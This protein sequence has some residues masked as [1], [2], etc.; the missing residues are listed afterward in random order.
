[1][2][3]FLIFLM[4]LH[5]LLPAATLNAKRDPQWLM[6]LYF[7]D[8][9]GDRDTVYFG[10]DLEAST[11]GDDS[12]LG[13]EWMIIDTSKFNIYLFQYPDCHGADCQLYT[14]N[15][16][17]TD[18]RNAFLGTSI[19]FCKGKLPITMKWVDSLLYAPS[20]PFP[21]LSPRPRARIDITCSEYD[22]GYWSC[23]PIDGPPLSLTDYPAPEIDYPVIDSFFIDGS[24]VYPPSD[25]ILYLELS[26]VRHNYYWTGLSLPDNKLI[27]LFPNPF[28]DFV[29]IRNQ[30][31]GKLTVNVMSLSGVCL[32][33]CE[34]NT[35]ELVMN[36][37]SLQAGVYLIL[38]QTDNKFYSQKIVKTE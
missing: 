26:L 29:T 15:V 9:N 25:V 16:K 23:N 19:G 4:Q 32:Y 5:L 10:Y 13:E 27:E 20:C 35:K 12:F 30:E 11:F 28:I 24:G 2:K 36:L 7:R 3:T 6:P 18:I 21:D 14:N 17:K 22:P 8:A 33:T 38:L 34:T 37:S 31:A 1:M